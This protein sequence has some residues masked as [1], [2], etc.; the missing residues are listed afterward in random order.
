MNLPGTGGVRVSART[1]AYIF[2]PP[3]LVMAVVAVIRLTRDIEIYDLVADPTSITHSPSYLGLLSV[4][5]GLCWAAGIGIFLTGACLMWERS[6]RPEAAFLLYS[7]AVTAYLCLDDVFMLH[8]YVLPEIGIPE[9]LAYAIILALVAGYL[10]LFR[11][12]ILAS[13][14]LFLVLAIGLLASSVAVDVIWEILDPPRG[15]T[16]EI[17]VEDGLKFTGI[18]AWV[19]YAALTTRACIRRALPAPARASQVDAQVESP[20]SAPDGNAGHP[21]ELPAGRG[22]STTLAITS[23]RDE[24]GIPGT[25]T[26][27]AGRSERVITTRRP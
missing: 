7:A 21:R 22:G 3:L 17:F 4:L 12:Q 19:A 1:L 6:R 10:V 14:W 24:P 20:A 23:S 8:E 26:K 25:G 9:F 13:S 15:S 11:R 2:V 5:G 16:L 18:C 27:G